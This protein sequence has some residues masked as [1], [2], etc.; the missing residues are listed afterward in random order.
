VIEITSSDS[1]IRKVFA[2]WYGGYTGSD[3]WQV[4]SGITEVTKYEDRI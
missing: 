4:S 1:T 3:A 2:G